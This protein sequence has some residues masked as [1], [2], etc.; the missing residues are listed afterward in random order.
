MPLDSDLIR[1][2]RGLP[3]GSPI[4]L[5]YDGTLV[6][7][8]TDPETTFPDDDVLWI[9]DRLSGKYQVYV[10]TG[11]SIPEITRF[12]DSRYN[13]IALHGAILKP[14]DGQPEYVTDAGE[15][16][17]KCDA[18]YA[19][20]DDFFRRYPGLKM[21]NK[22][23]GLVFIMWGLDEKA[24][25]SLVEEVSMLASQTGMDL[26]RGKR[27]VEL[28]IPG[29]NKGITIRGVR[30]GAPALIAGDDATD[31]D[32]FLDNPDAIT[33]K[34]GDG[35]TAARFRVRDVAEFRVLLKAMSE[36]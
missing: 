19:G 8:S 9:M 12:L 16:I 2:A 18:I 3:R 33:V 14:K 36:S 35:D 24:M 30:N 10:A 20:R 21:T 25:S 22:Q 26:Y 17:R 5:D 32:S 15:Y 27:I 7:L 31:E 6:P 1:E 34:V 4:F 11:R 23:G 13:F 28:R 29:V